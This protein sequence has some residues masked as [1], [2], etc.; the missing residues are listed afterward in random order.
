MIIDEIY[1]AEL[2]VRLSFL[3][4]GI[5]TLPQFILY[6]VNLIGDVATPTIVSVIQVLSQLGEIGNLM[7]VLVLIIWSAHVKQ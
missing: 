2:L 6:C 7:L 5:I 4:A 1:E 3:V